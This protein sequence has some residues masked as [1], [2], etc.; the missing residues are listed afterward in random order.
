MEKKE[1]KYNCHFD[2]VS[3]NVSS[4]NECTGMVPTPPTTESEKEGLQNIYSVP[5]KIAHIRKAKK[6]IKKSR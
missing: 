6:H 4:A 5:Q 2:F 3:L 1:D